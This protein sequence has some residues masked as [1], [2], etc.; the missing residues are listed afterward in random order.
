MSSNLVIQSQALRKEYGKTIAVRG[1]NLEVTCGEVF[2]FLGP[3]GAGK[4]TSLKMFLGLVAPT[5]GSA[6][7]LG[8]KPSDTAMRAHLGFLPEH[9]RFHEWLTGQEFLKLHGNLYSIKPS[10]LD[11]RIDELLDVVS[12]SGFRDKQPALTRKAC[13]SASGWRKLCSIT[14]N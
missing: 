10:V 5:S 1:L 11:N 2:G 7:V 8:R 12:L 6:E 9:F 4:T 13:C 14:L 3:N